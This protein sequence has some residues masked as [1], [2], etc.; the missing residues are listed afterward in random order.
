MIYMTRFEKFV[1]LVIPAAAVA[2]VSYIHYYGFDP[3]E[4]NAIL[5]GTIIVWLFGLLILFSRNRRGKTLAETT[6]NS[7]ELLEN[8]TLPEP[9]PGE[10]FLQW[11]ARTH[12]QTESSHQIHDPHYK[13]DNNGYIIRLP[14]S[15][16]C[17][18]RFTILDNPVSNFQEKCGFDITSE[19]ARLFIHVS[20]V[21]TAIR[22]TSAYGSDSTFKDPKL[23]PYDVLWL[24]DS[25]HNFDGL[26]RTIG[27]GDL[28]GIS[29]QCSFLLGRYGEYQPTEQN[30]HLS[31]R[32]SF[33]RY[34][35]FCNPQEVVE[36]LTAIKQKADTA[37]E[38][39]HT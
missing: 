18:R 35:R 26:G 24:S 39:A 3:K 10:S 9:L 22:M 17:H 33:E 20:R 25:L 13:K 34:S 14:D 29:V 28:A 12:H 38:A 1:L 5:C 4:H 16:V 27:Q 7:P 30:Q 32:N 19:M 23:I 21:A 31:S 11:A 8:P 2:M 15:E 6:E 37:M 36:L